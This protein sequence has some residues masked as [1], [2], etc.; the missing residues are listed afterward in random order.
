MNT[1]HKY[2]YIHTYKIAICNCNVKKEIKT[3]QWSGKLKKK[4]HAQ[5]VCFTY[6]YI[7]FPF[8]P[9]QKILTFKTELS[10]CTVCLLWAWIQ[11]KATEWG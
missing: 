7:P 8:P 3:P 6:T 10:F 11:W 2:T 9:G 4:V 1:M 5:Y